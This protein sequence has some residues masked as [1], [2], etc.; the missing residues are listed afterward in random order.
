MT[1]TNGNKRPLGIPTVV[2][3]VVQQMVAQIL[4]LGY[5]KYFSNNSYGFRPNRDCHG[6][7]EKALEYLNEGYEWVIDLD[8]EKYFD[9]VNH[10]K[11]ISILRERINDAKTLRLIRCCPAN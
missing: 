11:L 10:D 9:T 4:S 5:D 6:A 7:I 8:I 1:P 3:R 2:D